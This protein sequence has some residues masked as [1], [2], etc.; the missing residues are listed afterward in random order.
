M[1]ILPSCILP[2]RV[3]MDLFAFIRHADP[4][5]NDNIEN[6]GHDDL[7][8]KSSDVDQED[9][10]EESDHAS[11][12]ETTTILRDKEVQAAAA[13][14]SKRT[15]K[16]RRATGGASGSNY[17]PKKLRE[18][19]GTSGN[20]NASTGGKSLAVIQSL[21]VRSTLN[22]EGGGNTDSISGPNLRTQRP[23]ERSSVSPPLMMTAAVTTIIIVGASSIPTLGVG[24]D[25]VT[26]V[27][28]SLFAD[29]AY[30]VVSVP[31]I[32]VPKW[33]VVNESI[34]DDP[35]VCRSVV[36][37]L[38][39]PGLFFHLRGMDYDQLFA[40]ERKR[41]ERRYARQ[42]DLLKEKDV[43]IANLKAQLSLKEAEATEAIYLRNQVFII[44]ATE[45][46]RVSELDSVKGQNIALEEEKN[47]LK[48]QV[49]TLES[50]AVT[51]DTEL[52]YL[53]AQTAKLTQDLSKQCKAIQDA[54]L[55]VLSDRV[56][57]LDSELIALAFH[58]DE[59]FYPRF[60][61]TIAGQRWIIGH[62]LRLVVM[63]FRQSPKKS[64]RGL[65][66]VAS[67]DPSMEA[68][69]FLLRLQ[70][71]ANYSLHMNNSYCLFTERRIMLLS[72]RLLFDPL[73]S[74]NL[75]G[76]AGTSEVP[77]K[78]AA[79]TTLSI[80]VT[81][82]SASSIPPISVTNYDVLDAGIQNEA[83]PSPKIVFEKE[84]LKTTPENPTAS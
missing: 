63:K 2:E 18:D 37:Q 33:N 6:I 11:H 28:Q 45:A 31:Y 14:K 81:A 62:G 15:R 1:F 43:E 24:T 12:D 50:V 75:I 36:D 21:L 48:G 84:T 7:N 71:L 30:I 4:T 74:K 58:L 40:K 38:A 8:E 72:E 22:V 19:H 27:Y 59:E 42:V 46:T 54:Q 3:E 29:S 53:N 83:P 76:E 39:P 9:H 25:L 68:R 52:A 44:K 23:S 5:K 61:T 66:D 35:N 34:L 80:L 55:K 82:T 64:G 47:T 56:A 60:L 32:Y 16:K 26:Q 78:A 65:A 67:Y 49:M 20:V 77:A 69:A 73:S 41:F 57:G 17:P 70:R 79:T 13:D 10:Y 51:K